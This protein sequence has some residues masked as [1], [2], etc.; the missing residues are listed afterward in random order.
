MSEVDALIG[1]L[2]IALRDM[3]LAFDRTSDHWRDKTRDEFYAQFIEPLEQEL[4]Q[5]SRSI[6][7]ISSVLSRVHSDCSN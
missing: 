7:T 6:A 5:A 4:Q 2:N 3:R 1:E